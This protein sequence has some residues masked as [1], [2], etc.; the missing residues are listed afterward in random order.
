MSEESKVT[1][2]A[3]N[4]THVR[5]LVRQAIDEFVR[6]QQ[7]K[8]EPAYKTELQEERKRR[9]SLETRLNQLVEENRKARAAAEEA[10]RSSQIRTELQRLGVSKVDLAFR[11]VKDDIVRA[12]DGRLQGRG[13]DGK[14]LQDFLATFVQENPELLPARIA[15]GSGVQAGQRSSHGG[16]PGIEIDKIKPGMKPEELER[17]RQE[18]SR[19]AAQALRGA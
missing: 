12:E 8:A 13:N 15:G 5:D 16:A 18:I 4:E 17:V 9:E 14:S 1:K 2:E 11:A 10:D 19:L 6:V 7:S 3:E